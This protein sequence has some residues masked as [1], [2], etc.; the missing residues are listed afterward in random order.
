MYDDGLY[1]ELN[2]CFFLNNITN[3]LKGQLVKI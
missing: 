1:R 3:K 2:Y